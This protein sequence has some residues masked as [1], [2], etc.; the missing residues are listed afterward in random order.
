MQIFNYKAII[1]RY[2]QVHK[3]NYF[4]NYFEIKIS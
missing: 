1:N 3:S 2:N 4:Y